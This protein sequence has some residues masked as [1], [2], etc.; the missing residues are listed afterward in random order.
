MTL[1]SD[2]LAGT[3]VEMGGGVVVGGRGGAGVQDSVCNGCRAP[4][5]MPP[6]DSEQMGCG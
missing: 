6:P 5:W 4:A 3:S 1:V 2:G